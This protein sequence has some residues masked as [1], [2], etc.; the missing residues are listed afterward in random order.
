MLKKTV[1]FML[2]MCMILAA[3]PVSAAE[4]NANSSGKKF[5]GDWNVTSI[6][7]ETR[8]FKYGFNTAAIDEDYTHTYHETKQHTAYVKNSARVQSVVKAEGKYA[9]AEI[10][11]AAGTVYYRYSY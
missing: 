4:Y 10:R 5:S 1:A 3:V 11:H 7:T 8:T 6:N 2:A 9:K